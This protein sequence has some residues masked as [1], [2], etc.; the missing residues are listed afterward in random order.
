M[1]EAFIYDAVRTPRGRGKPDGAL[2][3]V[4]PIRLATTVLGA[5]R[6]RLHLDTAHIDDVILGVVS[7]VGEQGSNI[8]RVAAI[9]AGYAET[10]ALGVSAWVRV[11]VEP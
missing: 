9:E 2:H 5:L 4:P 7:P 3:P 1:P 10:V 11:E 8:A 6:E